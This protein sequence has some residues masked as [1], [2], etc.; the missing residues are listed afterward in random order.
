MIASHTKD[1][2][3]FW[4]FN[5]K[6]R[7]SLTVAFYYTN[8]SFLLK[9]CAEWRESN[10]LHAFACVP[11][12]HGLLHQSHTK[13]VCLWCKLCTLLLIFSRGSSSSPRVLGGRA[14]RGDH[15]LAGI[16]INLSVC[17]NT[18]LHGKLLGQ[19]GLADMLVPVG[20]YCLVLVP[21]PR[22]F[23][24]ACPHILAMIKHSKNQAQPL[25]T[26]QV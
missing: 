22:L 19:N 15:N 24:P 13:S 18:R 7:L 4:N 10:V 8:D 6:D 16:D 12:S 17:T 25:S 26:Y 11:D 14:S 9:M 20:V 2:I 5:L 3:L 23:M 21:L 1:S